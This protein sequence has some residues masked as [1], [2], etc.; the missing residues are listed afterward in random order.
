MKIPGAESQILEALWRKAPLTFDELVADVGP[1]NG[2]AAGTV[3]TLVT[4]L[5]RKKAIEGLKTD[6]GYAYRPLIARSSYVRS[7]SQGLLDRLFDGEVTPLVA[8]LAEHRAL[9]PADLKKLEALIAELKAQ[10]DA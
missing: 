7:E 8:A 1:A 2:W 5:L 3:R 10:D 6:Y 4:R 9:T